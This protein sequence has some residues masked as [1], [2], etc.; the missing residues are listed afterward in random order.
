MRNTIW[1]KRRLKKGLHISEVANYLDISYEK[2]AL[3]DKGDIK[4]PNKYIEKFNKLMNKSK[5]ETSIDRLTR[6]EIVNEWWDKMSQKKGHGQFNLNEKMIEF[7]IN[8]LKELDVLLGYT[9][10]SGTMS[11]YLNGHRHISFDA[12]N[13]VYS[14]FENE[15]NIQPPKIKQE[16]VIKSSKIVQSSAEYKELLKWYDNFDL[17]EWM[18]KY[19]VNRKDLSKKSGL[20][21][22][23]IHNII[24][25]KHPTPTMSV[26]NK[27]K[28]FVDNYTEKHANESMSQTTTFTCVPTKEVP[29]DSREMGR[30]LTR[31][32]NENMSLKE[33][34]TQ[35]Y[36]T[37]I[38]RLSGIIEQH[39]LLI[40]DL[41]KE[42]DFYEKIINDINED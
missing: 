17:K 39:E 23:T 30:E 15:L 40:I 14:F 20:S 38:E 18:N 12:K 4:M 5:G 1:K 7:N 32:A 13:K 25:K 3:I 8:S 26:M 6:E 27:L 29:E 31:E 11:N 21:A 22:G 36:E 34:L 9:R 16:K 28:I 33:K 41:K 2:Y 24:K 42:K 19:S 35:K 37:E 10:E